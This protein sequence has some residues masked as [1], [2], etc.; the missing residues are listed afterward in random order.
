MFGI[1]DNRRGA[2]FH[3]DQLLHE[4]RTS[5]VLHRLRLHP[6]I[7]EIFGDTEELDSEKALEAVDDALLE[8]PLRVTGVGTTGL[9]WTKPIG[10]DDV[11]FANFTR[12]EGTHTT[13][14]SNHLD[15]QRVQIHPI[16]AE[17]AVLS[18]CPHGQLPRRFQVAVVDHRILRIVDRLDDARIDGR[19]V[20]GI[21]ACGLKQALLLI[22]Q[23]EDRGLACPQVKQVAVLI[24]E[25]RTEADVHE[26]V[27]VLGTSNS[28]IVPRDKSVKQPSGATQNDVISTPHGQASFV[29][30][31]LLQIGQESHAGPLC[32]QFVCGLQP[33][34]PAESPALE[35]GAFDVRRVV[36][37]GLVGIP[38][39]RCVK[40]R[41]VVG[42][43]GIGTPEKGGGKTRQRNDELTLTS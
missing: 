29:T 2:V 25:V 20:V 11:A 23:R 22:H 24:A 10:T 19:P 40:Q 14:E 15:E 28:G 43:H 31:I 42:S 4:L 36:S 1:R 27:T 16:G 12:N 5:E 38:E 30:E 32:D 18:K 34:L 37:I 6:V 3:E 7:A 13:Y 17:H 9:E 21:K 41:H 39:G 35:H 26:R 33:V 8:H